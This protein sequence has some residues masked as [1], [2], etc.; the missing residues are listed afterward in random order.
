MKLPGLTKFSNEHCNRDQ[1]KTARLLMWCVE[2]I[3]NSVMVKNFASNV[4]HWEPKLW[5]GEKII[6]Y[7][8]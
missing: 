6:S 2:L 3:N 4:V 5:L 7:D 1:E 8:Y